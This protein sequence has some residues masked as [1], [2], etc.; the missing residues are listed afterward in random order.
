MKVPVEWLKEHVDIGVSIDEIADRLTMA[1]LEV[2]EIDHVSPVEVKK[3]GGEGLG[4]EDRVLSTTVTP[5]RGDWLSIIGTAREAAAVLGE[6][7]RV[8]DPGGEGT[9]P[10]ASDAIKIEIHDPDLCRRYVGMLIRNVKIKESPGWMKDRIIR[11]GLRPI[12]NI[13]D[14]TNYVMIE[15]GQ[16]LHAFDYVLLHGQKIIVRRARRGEKIVSIDGIER[17]LQQDMLVIADADRAV[18]IAGVM[19]GVDSEV[20]ANTEHILLESANFDPVSVR[21]TSKMLSMVTESSY[22]FEREVDPGITEIAAR[23]AAEL[24]RELADGEIA[25]GVVDAYPRPA[26]DVTIPVS[27]E[28]VNR[29]LG[30]DLSAGL[31]VQY[32]RR[33]EIPVKLDGQLL[34]TAPTFRPDIRIEA[35]VAEEIGRMHGYENIDCTLPNSPMQGCDSTIGA[36]SATLREIIESC[37]AQEV[38]SH[39]L[40]D[41][42]LAELAG[43]SETMLRIR[44]PLSEELGSV[45]TML[46]PNLLQ[47]IALNQARGERD[48]SVFEVGNVFSK[49]P[50]GEPRESNSVAMA[51][52]GNQWASAWGLDARALES[53]FYLCKGALEALMDRLH[54]KPVDFSPAVHPLLHPARA[55]TVSIGDKPVGIIGEVSPSVNERLDIRGRPC[56]FELDL[57]A[58]CMLATER[59]DYLETPRFPML[60][61]DLAVVVDKEIPYS[62]LNE[63]L[64]EA[65]G[66]FLEAVEARDV[67]VGPHVEQNQKSITISLAFRSRERT[68]TDEEVGS[69]LEQMKSELTNRFSATFRT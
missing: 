16:P 61:R 35:D 53:D 8:E 40:V 38:V 55:A 54:V 49:M 41:P 33:L 43:T 24:M 37:G 3:H 66:E 60:R 39:S 20:S 57:D 25:S 31:M 36:F 30:T 48:I 52:V 65:G 22:R 68:L 18:A 7:R 11:A 29:L 5:N 51:M 23:R 62:A 9:G 64:R 13:V 47:V 58:L 59:R 44:N 46:A 15:Y 56:V 19:G 27:P 10:P 26:K 12:N 17:D 2:E 6:A 45:R 69:V 67:Y 1:G 14:I 42:V 63:T 50:D 34:V 4:V 32:L 28:K 21:R